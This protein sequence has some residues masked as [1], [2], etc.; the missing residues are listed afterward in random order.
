MDFK[1]VLEKFNN[2]GDQPITKDQALKAANKQPV[3]ESKLEPFELQEGIT[4]A[5]D[6]DEAMQLLSKLSGIE[7]STVQEPVPVGDYEY[8]QADMYADPESCAADNDEYAIAY[9]DDGEEYEE[10]T[11]E[12]ENRPEEDI[13]GMEDAIPSG[14]DLHKEKSSYKRAE[15]GDNPMNTMEQI[16]KALDES[17]HEDEE[18]DSEDT[19]DDSDDDEVNESVEESDDEEI[20]EDEESLEESLNRLVEKFTKEGYSRP[21]VE[22]STENGR[23]ILK[24]DVGDFPA[25][26]AKKVAESAMKKAAKK[27][28]LWESAGE[29][30]HACWAKHPEKGYKAFVFESEEEK[31]KAQ[32]K[33]DAFL[34]YANKDFSIKKKDSVTESAQRPVTKKSQISESTQS[35]EEKYVLEM[36]KRLQR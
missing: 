1:N 36:T 14:D 9:E 19:E 20:E 18:G 21:V 16:L 33:R 34:E 30:K 17:D 24:M 15:P 2:M 13:Y 27:K 23:K 32:K 26:E 4:I 28:V 8:A 12:Y 3:N 11:A 35:A 29:D 22:E 25:N 6:G 10:D 7:K 5:A 31:S